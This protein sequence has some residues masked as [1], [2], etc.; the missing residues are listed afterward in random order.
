MI[1]SRLRPYFFGLVNV[2]VGVG[3]LVSCQ[4]N[5][6]ERLSWET[7]LT[8]P[9]A[10]TEVG[11][12]D[13]LTDTGEFELSTTG[14]TRITFRDTVASLKVDE[15][16][17]FPDT[18]TQYLAKLDGLSLNSDTITQRITLAEIARQLLADPST[19]TIGQ[20]ILNNH[21]QSLPFFPGFQGLSSGP[22]EVDATDFFEFAELE[23]GLLAISIENQLPLTIQNVIFRLGNLTLLGPDLVRDTFASI[24]VGS[25]VSESYDLANK[26][27]ESQLVGE[28]ENVDL[29]NGL[30]VQVDTNDY[31]EIRLSA[32]DLRARRATAIFPRQVI[33]D[34][35]ESQVYE[36]VGDFEGLE[37]T[38]LQVRRG[39]IQAIARSTVADTIA[40][41]YAL[42]NARD[43]DGNV[44]SL[45]LKLNP[46]PPNGMIEQTET[47]EL[48]GFLVDLTS[49]GK[50]FN[51][52]ENSILVE[53]LPSGRKIT[54]AQT[55]SVVVDFSLLDIDATY[56]E[57]YMGQ[58]KFS[59]EGEE[60]LDLFDNIDV[61]RINLAE[62]TAEIVF[63]NSI[64]INAQLELRKLEAQ[65]TRTSERVRLAGGPL[66]AG[67]LTL[68]GPQLPDT[69]GVVSTSLKF[70][71]ANSNLNPFLSTLPDQVAYD[72]EVFTNFDGTPG[73]RDNF[74]TSEGSIDVFLDMQVPFVG[75]VQGLRL[76]DT[77]E[78]DFSS[79]EA[80]AIENGALKL[81]LENDFPISVK[82]TAVAL[83]ENQQVV[84]TLLTN[85]VFEAGV[86]NETGRVP[87]PKQSVV[88]I[89]GADL[90]IDRILNEAAYVAFKFELD[91]QP[92]ASPVAIYSD[93]TITAK[94]VGRFQTEL[95]ATN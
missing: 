27:V 84:E 73:K 26:E 72:F 69:N 12:L 56:V 41:R 76:A 8:A 57:G 16:I 49:G 2:V 6:L 71:P 94:L 30:N 9:I 45:V 58:T 64:G 37:L 87:V 85:G 80:E 51:T 5:P 21:G 90:D 40:F 19:A 52:I 17:E 7:D 15:L 14:I 81:V 86:I 43:A 93:Y 89:S 83:D 24:P 3:L 42:P 91:T 44:P 34:T 47:F 48:D 75:S 11:I 82:V 36:A 68:L 33:Y 25:T 18:S 59:Y 60:T 39:R 55:D 10:Y 22:I 23:S 79:V 63:E 74:I 78:V 54:L 61:D 29:A 92:T 62:T 65:N 35:T 50:G 46:A 66:V 28:L 88:S 95:R 31:I 1:S 77:T 53:L 70:D 67:P 13:A 20:L 38:K 32:Q 4:L